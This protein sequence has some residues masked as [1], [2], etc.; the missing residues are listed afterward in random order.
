MFL[1]FRF[2]L[3]WIKLGFVILLCGVF[4]LQFLLI[5][6][7]IFRSTLS[8][9]Y[10]F[11]LHYLQSLLLL[12]DFISHWLLVVLSII[13]MAV[14]GEIFVL[15]IFSDWIWDALHL[16]GLKPLLNAGIH[17]L[18]VIFWLF[19]NRFAHWFLVWILQKL[20]PF[21]ECVIVYL[22]FLIKFIMRIHQFV[23]LTAKIS[24]ID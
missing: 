10:S 6:G 20:N 22:S 18:W 14:V 16:T 2:I 13:M 19:L 1:T 3:Q 12:A 21:N 8:L 7:W 23:L 11:F 15:N 4:L 24:L 9:F 17:N 5:W